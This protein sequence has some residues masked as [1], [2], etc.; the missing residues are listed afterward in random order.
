MG[1]SAEV[2]E[3]FRQR[4]EPDP[5]PAVWPQHWHAAQVFLGLATQ[6]R[7]VAGM[8]GLL[9][10]GLDYGA[11]QPVLEEHAQ[12]AHQQPMCTLMPQLRVMEQEARDQLNRS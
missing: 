2:I 6:W 3:A 4:M 9:Y 5:E 12:V 7:V 10:T 11:M 1:A 8:V